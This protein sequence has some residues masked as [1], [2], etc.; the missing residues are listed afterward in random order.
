LDEA[1][2]FGLA[3]KLL[4]LGPHQT[5]ELSHILHVPMAAARRQNRRRHGLE[6]LER[7]FRLRRAKLQPEGIVRIGSDISRGDDSIP[8]LA[9]LRSPAIAKK[10]D[11]ALL[12]IVEISDQSDA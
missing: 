4:A 1:A 11:G 7:H 6:S 2:L 10:E 12:R 8:V 9:P 3:K 5:F